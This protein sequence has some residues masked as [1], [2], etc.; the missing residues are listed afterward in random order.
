[1]CCSANFNSPSKNK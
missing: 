1:M